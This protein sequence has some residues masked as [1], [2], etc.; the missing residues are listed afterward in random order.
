MNSKN[1]KYILR[2]WMAAMAYELADKGD[3]TLVQELAKL[4]ENPYGEGSAEDHDKWFVK[5]PPW[6]VNRPGIAYLSCSS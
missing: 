2:N 6:A 5:T 4:L 1:P 3:Y